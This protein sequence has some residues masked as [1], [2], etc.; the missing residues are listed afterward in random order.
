MDAIILAGGKGTRL[1]SVVSDVPKPL[2]PVNNRPFLDIIFNFLN[3]C[4]YIDNVIIAAGY[5]AD[6]IIKEY[7]NRREYSFSILFSVEDELLGTGGA[8]KRAMQFSQSEDFI[9]LNGDSYIELNLGAFI[10]THLKNNKVM[11][12]V[13][14]EVEN[15]NRYGRV[16]LDDNNRIIYFEEKNPEPSKGYINA[17]V[18]LIKRELFEKIEEN[19]AISLERDLLPGFI[20]DNDVY[21]YLCEGKFIDI[22]IPE[23][24]II[25]SQFF[26][27]E[28]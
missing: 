11:T 18:Y 7:Q 17:G 19:E 12:I 3:K 8:I 23:T 15:A 20:K 6:K 10:Q 22:G 2:A 21:G 13:L 1:Q 27:T 25:S 9:V 14:K 5:M 4:N 26:E 16:T 28:A 24:Y